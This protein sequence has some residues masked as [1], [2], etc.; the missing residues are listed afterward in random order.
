MTLTFS[1]CRVHVGYV[2]LHIVIQLTLLDSINHA[3]LSIVFT[4]AD[5]IAALLRL[6]AKIPSLKVIVSFDSLDDGVRSV[7]SSWAESLGIR[8]MHLSEGTHHSFYRVDLSSLMLQSSTMARNILSSHLRRPQIRSQIYAT[9]QY[10]D[11]MAWICS[12]AHF[13][14]PKGTT[15][16]P[17]GK[18]QVRS[19]DRLP[20]FTSGVILTHGNL[21]SA[22]YSL[23]FGAHFPTSCCLISYL[24][25]AHIYEVR[26]LV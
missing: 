2:G 20:H 9:H 17:K 16:N 8:I 22:V 26:R 10:V 12:L 3:Q 21:A 1:I 6:S 11:I 14:F 24:P 4:T 18:H 13:G 19:E 23:M 15:N 25:L 5:H 7:L